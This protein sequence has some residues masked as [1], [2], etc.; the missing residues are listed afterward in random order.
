[1]N[2]LPSHT[3]PSN[4]RGMVLLT[5]VL[6][7]AVL[8]A[9]GTTAILQTSTDIKI[10]GN[11][12]QSRVALYNAEA[13]M[14]QVFNYLSTNAVT[15]PSAGTPTTTITVSCPTG[16]NF[17]TSVTLHYVSAG[18]Y[19]F[20]MTGTAANS[21]SRTIEAYFQRTPL[22]PQGA[23]GAVAMYGGNPQVDFKTGGGGGF[24]IDGHDYPIPTSNPCTGSGCNTS[25]HAT[26]ATTGLYTVMSP[27]IN[28]NESAH[29]G[30]SPT[31]QVGGG[32][33]TEASWTAFVDYVLANNLYQTTFGTRTNP[34]V[35]VIP[36]GST[37]NGNG[38]YAGIIIVDDGGELRLNGTF[39]FEGLI[40][41][42]GTGEMRG[43][44]TGNVFGSVITIGHS[45]KTIDV[46]GTVDLFF[47]SEA[48]ANL[49]NINALTRT[50]P[51]A[52]RDVL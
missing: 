19:R 50:T 26:G 14:A 15:L 16:Y 17:N 31:R 1:M 7:V 24:N 3:I 27:T 47:S 10:S 51:T 29:L 18:T 22:Y 34:A 39:T 43:S 44:G 37:L 36:S 49:A 30:G 40:I 32:V 4:Q 6:L 28:G 52:W 11:Y 45:S 23:D 41:M 12:R 13:G 48:L 42:R 46:T 25:P 21:A 8:M 35:T 20:Q 33:N 38:H 5:V 9:L 2:K